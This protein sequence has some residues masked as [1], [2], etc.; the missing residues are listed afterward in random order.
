M[1]FVL[2]LL[3]PNDRLKYH[4]TNYQDHKNNKNKQDPSFYRCVFK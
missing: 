2:S 4:S 3:Y 1:K